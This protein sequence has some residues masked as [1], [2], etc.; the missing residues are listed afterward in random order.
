[1]FLYRL[2]YHPFLVLASISKGKA[3][4]L[5]VWICALLRSDTRSYMIGRVVNQVDELI[6][7]RKDK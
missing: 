6:Y 7:K 5:F 1:M 3:Y 2:L 4:T